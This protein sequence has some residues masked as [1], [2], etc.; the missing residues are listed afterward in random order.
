MKL[1]L[2]RILP[3]DTSTYLGPKLVRILTGLYMVIIVVRSCI[4]L[5]TADGGSHSI[6]GVNVSVAG[7]DN[8]IAMFHQWGAIQLILV[9]LL[10]V[11]FFRY[12]GLTSLILFALAMDPIM[13]WVAAQMK[14]LVTV[15]TPPGA[16]LNWPSFF[17]L[18]LLLIASLKVKKTT[19]NTSR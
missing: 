17:F 16:A 9:G 10:Y 14:P 2:K 3:K 6:A 19:V 5:F 11:L 7:G 12:P 8:I 1:S 4:H 18:I 15:G 13:R